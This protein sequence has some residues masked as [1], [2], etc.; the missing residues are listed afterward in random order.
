TQLLRAEL[1]DRKGRSF[2]FASLVEERELSVIEE[3]V[4]SGLTEVVAHEIGHCL[5]LRHNFKGSMAI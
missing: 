4:G 1:A 5:G 2:G 3:L